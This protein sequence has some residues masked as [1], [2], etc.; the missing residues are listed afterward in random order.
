M[1]R[2]KRSLWFYRYRH[3]KRGEWFVLL[4]PTDPEWE[5]VRKEAR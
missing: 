2:R 5:Y 3:V 4:K 1:R